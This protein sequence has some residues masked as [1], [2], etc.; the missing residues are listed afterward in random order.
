MIIAKSN[1]TGTSRADAVTY[2]RTIRSACI[3]KP[4]IHHWIEL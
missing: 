4:I 2:N 3:G 1:I